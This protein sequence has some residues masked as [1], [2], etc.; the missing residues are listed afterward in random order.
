MIE[1]RK[2]GEGS[3][4][5]ALRAIA[6]AWAL[7]AGHPLAAQTFPQEPVRL[8]VPV[9]AG[10]VTDLM[11]RLLAQGLSEIWGQ[12]VMVEN[13]PGGNHGVAAQAT[14]RARPDGHVMMVVAD[15]TFTANPS[16]SPKLTYR[17]DEFTP[18]ALLS[19]AT[20]MFVI[21]A[22][23]P[24]TS[25][26]SFI[27]YAKANPGKLNYGSYGIGTYAHLGM[28][29]FKARTGTEL[30]HVPYPGAA[31]ALEGLLRGDISALLLNL[32][33]IEQHESGG[34]LRILAAAGKRR[35]ASRPE[36]A[37]VDEQGVSGFETSNWFGLFGPA[38]MPPALVDK[39]Q[40]DVRRVLA[41]PRVVEMFA[42]NSFE[43]QAITSA[44]FAQV[45]AKDADYW[46]KIIQRLGLRLD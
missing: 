24:A 36:L 43:A 11:A 22:T 4:R 7:C 42:K 18:I 44:Q 14:A 35:A 3:M 33:S 13:R 6:F 27:A 30:V 37:T 16:L 17:V 2:E 32:S 21:N 45:I 15:T 5:L 38:G 20:P 23:V 1:H 8:L 46:R 26:P 28:E 9:P 10:G 25:I 12:S 39:I 19:R 31:P 40:Q 34:K 41:S 29:D